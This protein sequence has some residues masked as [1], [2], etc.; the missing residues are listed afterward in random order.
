LEPVTPLTASASRRCYAFGP[1]R[2]DPAEA[3]LT[4]DGEQIKLPPKALEMLHALVKRPGHLM[5]KAELLA[6]VWPGLFVEEGN[7]TVHM[8][9]L[10]RALGDET[11]DGYIE[12]VPKR[13]Y[14]FTGEVRVIEAVGAETHPSG[15]APSHPATPTASP[16][17]I[18][19]HATRWRW[20]A[21]AVMVIAAVTIA[22]WQ[23]K[24]SRDDAV[25]FVVVMP[26]TAVTGQP[27]QAY[28][29][30]GLAEAITSRLSQ[31]RSMRVAPIAA[32]RAN[33][34]PFSEAERLGVDAVLTGSVQREGS[35]LRVSA[36]L[37]VPADRRVIWSEQFNES[38]ADIFALQDRIAERIASSLG[39]RLSA[40]D[41]AAL[42]RHETPNSD[43]YDFYLRA[44]EEWSHRTPESVQT[45]IA[46]YGKAIALDTN[47]AL[48]YA[49]LADSYNITRSGLPAKVRYPLAKAAAERAL[50]LDPRLAEAQT[51]RAFQHYKFEWKWSEAESRFKTAIALDS[52]YALAHHW[53]ADCLFLLGRDQESII[54][55]RKAVLLDP[56]SASM[57]HDLG[58]ALMH[59]GDIAGARTAT[60]A[61]LKLNQNDAQLIVGLSEILAAEGRE[62]ESVEM[63]LR[64]MLI[65]GATV[66]EVD[67]SRAAYKR[68][69]V[70]GMNREAVVQLLPKAN[71]G[72]R[73][74]ATL[75]AQAYGRLGDREHTLE[76]LTQ[77]VDRSEDGA[78]QLK[79]QKAYAFLRGDPDFRQLLVR[80]G[81]EAR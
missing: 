19:S 9:A 17:P 21:A 75:L 18:Q 44:R 23:A 28:L 42:K 78:I 60:E 47:F 68:G 66:A 24:D 81:F 57:R 14:R 74:T 11:R 76:W 67:A 3:Q 13:G 27:D 15:A 77:A 38:A 22:A 71:R 5:T 58:R 29:E 59:A 70:D 69:G 1:F 53:Y 72:E 6:E 30:V 49:G 10:R 43:A 4:R 26:F 8:T 54:E 56:Y 39:R 55:Y 37:S 63:R 51:A 73:Q 45:A 35:R 2:L 32:I 12:T 7:L 16:I 48:A 62:A 80:V 52:T 65:R 64:A 20:L 33:S 50:S 41:R 31:L 61:G 46:L 79:S 40:A 36:Q 34:D 25:Q